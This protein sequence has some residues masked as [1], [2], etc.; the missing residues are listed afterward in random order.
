MAEFKP[1]A[2][3]FICNWCTYTG[4]DLAG[5][6]RM[7][8]P[9]DFRII[10]V[11][12]TGRIDAEFIIK[13]FEQGADGIWISGCHIGDC[14]Y[15][16][17]NYFAQRRW[18]IFHDELEFLGIDTRRLKYTWISA[19][20][21]RKFADEATEFVERLKELGPYEDFDQIIPKIEES[22]ASVGGDG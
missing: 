18:S 20:E 2:I 4:A 12:C 10:K 7:E 15:Q 1:K 11:P 14:H 21:G 13:G 16:S 22:G 8:Y 5:T 17:G 9:A 3:A 19:S 6:S